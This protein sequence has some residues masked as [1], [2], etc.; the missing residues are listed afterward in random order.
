[1]SKPD[2][3]TGREVL[4]LSELQALNSQ[5]V[6][7]TDQ[8]KAYWREVTDYELE[9]SICTPYDQIDE[10]MARFYPNVV[11]NGHQDVC[12]CPACA[13]GEYDHEYE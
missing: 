1:M 6:P 9:I 4:S 11:G 10:A 3:Y 2:P 7:Q 12:L 8:E 5:E 13:P